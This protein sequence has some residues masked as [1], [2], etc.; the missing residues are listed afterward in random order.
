M[1]L[2]NF[3]KEAWNLQQWWTRMKEKKP[4]NSLSVL[5]SKTKK[6]SPIF[7]WRKLLFSFFLVLSLSW[8][9]LY[10]VLNLYF[11][12]M[13]VWFVFKYVD[14]FFCRCSI[15]G[16]I[17][18]IDY[19]N[20]L[21]FFDEGISCNSCATLSVAIVGAILCQSLAH[22][23][24]E[25]VRDLS[26]GVNLK[27]EYWVPFRSIEVWSDLSNTSNCFTRPRKSSIIVYGKLRGI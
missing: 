18:S 11:Y 19:L 26:G 14:S 3:N 15:D 4:F 13:L 1:L 23:V 25:V 22:K 24:V 2:G 8:E 12:C 7:V 21:K 10:C 27:M 16:F 17:A 5:E 20:G 9:V 6:W